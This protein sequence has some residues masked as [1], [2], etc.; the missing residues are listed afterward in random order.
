M[1]STISSNAGR[2]SGSVAQQRL[3]RATKSAGVPGGK[4]GRSWLAL[5]WAIMASLRGSVASR[6]RVGWVG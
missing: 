2:S 5:T 4:V 6:L 1:I 3:A